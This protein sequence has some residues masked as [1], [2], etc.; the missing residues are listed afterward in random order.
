MYKRQIPD[1]L[2]DVV[3]GC[4]VGGIVG[5]RLYYV[6]F[7]WDTFKNDLGSI[8]KTWE[9]G[10]AIYGG[11]IGAILV[12]ALIVKLRKM[13]LL[14]VL[15]IACM[16]FLIGQAIGRWGNFVNVEAFGSNTSLPWG[17]TGERVTS[18]LSN[19]ANVE[20]LSKLGVTV[21]ALAPVRCV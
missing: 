9:G 2:I 7:S 1:K 20:T 14:P 17:M 8:I 21:D 10:M 11:L 18:Y 4:V 12:G 16:G 15:D 6:A 19:S 3:L 5:A 13:K